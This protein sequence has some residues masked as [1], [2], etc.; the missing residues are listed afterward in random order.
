MILAPSDWPSSIIQASRPSSLDSSG[1]FSG[2]AV[3]SELTLMFI[4]DLLK[5][6][7]MD[8]IG[9]SETSASD[10][11]DSSE[12]ISWSNPPTDFRRP[13]LTS[14]ANDFGAHGLELLSCGC[15]LRGNDT[16]PALR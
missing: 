1:R 8:S 12:S 9:P 3:F 5:A 14:S 4:N 2:V 6:S 13:I 16:L 7:A 11:F 10:T 15:V